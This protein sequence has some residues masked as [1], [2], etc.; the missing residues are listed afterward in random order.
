MIYYLTRTRARPTMPKDII[1]IWNIHVQLP[2]RRQATCNFYHNN[3]SINLWLSL[4]LQQTKAVQKREEELKEQL[5]IQTEAH[6]QHLS[7][8]LQTQAEQLE[9]KWASQMEAKLSQ[10]ENYYQMELVKA[11]ARLRGI[12]A[13]GRYRC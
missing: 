3:L 11:F 5:F 1:S 9:A 4:V 12:E 2:L 8:A 10:Q 13:N 6:T 7:E